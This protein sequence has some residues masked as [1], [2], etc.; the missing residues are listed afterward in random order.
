MPVLAASDPALDLMVAFLGT[1][2]SWPLLI[3]VLLVIVPAVW[4]RDVRRRRRAR[5]VLRLLRSSHR[6]SAV[7]DE[8]HL[9]GIRIRR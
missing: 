3:L 9:L 5:Q 2:D 8:P 4:S 1:A 6:P 7:D